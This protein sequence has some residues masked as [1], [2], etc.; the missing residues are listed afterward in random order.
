MDTM[1]QTTN[2][3]NEASAMLCRICDHLLRAAGGSTYCT[4]NSQSLLKAVFGIDIEHDDPQ[5]HPARYCHC[6]S[7]TMSETCGIC[8]SLS[9]SQN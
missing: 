2:A 9:L 1:A 8:K 6:S 7:I 4:K 5:V 3:H